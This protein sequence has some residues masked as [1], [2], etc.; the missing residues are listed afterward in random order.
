MK[1]IVAPFPLRYLLVII[2]LSLEFNIFLIY[3]SY[4]ILS[5][6][7]E[8]CI[9]SME[10][11]NGWIKYYDT[12]VYLKMKCLYII[13]YSLKVFIYFANRKKIENAYYIFELIEIFYIDTY[14]YLYI[15]HNW[16]YIKNNIIIFKLSFLQ[17]CHLILCL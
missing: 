2:R 12:K 4:L 5:A 3:A 15:T 17:K 14:R 13:A 9:I 7:L 8:R 6:S 16:N 1:R 11:F 10:A